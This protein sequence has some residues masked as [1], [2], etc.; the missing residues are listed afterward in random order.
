MKT[1]LL[2]SLSLLLTS[3]G[4]FAQ[5]KTLYFEHKTAEQETQ[6]S[7]YVE[8]GFVSGTEY[9]GVPEKTAPTGRSPAPCAK[10]AS[11]M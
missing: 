1:H 11:S 6:V 8:E 5:A 4:A 2:T 9:S 7:L 3:L 10:T